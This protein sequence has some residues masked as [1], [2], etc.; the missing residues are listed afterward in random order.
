[1]TC[2]EKEGDQER[3][4]F[5]PEKERE[6]AY[7]FCSSVEPL[8]RVVLVY[9]AAYLETVYEVE[10]QSRWWLSGPDV[11]TRPCLEGTLCGSIVSRSEFDD[12]PPREPVL[13]VQFSVIRARLS[14]A[15][16]RSA[17]RAVAKY[18]SRED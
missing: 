16:V 9:P 14:V 7:L 12:M 11:L 6:L 4:E 1:M 2:S 13:A 5:E 17:P 15:R 18:G 3:A 8:L 10:R